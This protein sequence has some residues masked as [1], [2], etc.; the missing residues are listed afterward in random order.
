[1]LDRYKRAYE[2]REKM[3]TLAFTELEIKPLGDVYVA[4]GRWQLTRQGD[5]PRGRFTL[6]FRRTGDGWRII[7]D[8]TRRH[9]RG[10][11]SSGAVHD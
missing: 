7:H 1:M 4:T 3:G 10:R 2:T 11:S 9:L 5:T 8:H 6:V